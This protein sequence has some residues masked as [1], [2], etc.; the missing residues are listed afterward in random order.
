MKKV[1]LLI[2]SAFLPLS[3]AVSTPLVTET[4]TGLFQS[5]LTIAHSGGTDKCGCHYNRKT[6]QYHC[7]NRKQ[8]GGSCPA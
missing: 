4:N 1:K 8:R 6:G 2:F 7:H 5:N 3:F